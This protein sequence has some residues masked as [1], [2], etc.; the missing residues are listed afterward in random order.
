M[1]YIGLVLDE[2]LVRDNLDETI[3][4][5]WTLSGNNTY[6][7]VNTFTQVIQGTALR[8]LYSNTPNADLAEYYELY[9]DNADET[10]YN[11]ENCSG[12]LVEF[13]KDKGEIIKTKRNSKNFFSIISTNPGLTM[14]DKGQNNKHF[15]PVA[16]T[17]RVPCQVTGKVKKGDEL[18]TSDI[19][20]VARKKTF[21]DKLF[22]KPTV[23]IAL[24]EKLDN[25]QSKI[26]V[27]V[28]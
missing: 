2:H 15:V 6:T 25:Q 1:A 8:A 20:G 24:Q 22:G 27:F 4:G 18:T 5:N 23:G 16:L 17:G 12:Y 3:T 19:E 26:E 9:I 10:A 11:L 13:S 21:V 7:G 14:N 28:K